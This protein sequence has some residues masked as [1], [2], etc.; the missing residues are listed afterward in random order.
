VA[1]KWVVYLVQGIIYAN[2]VEN[3]LKEEYLRTKDLTPQIALTC[4]E[5]PSDVIYW[6]KN[7]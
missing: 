2:Y 6:G 4:F 3:L 1:N 7:I 5:Q